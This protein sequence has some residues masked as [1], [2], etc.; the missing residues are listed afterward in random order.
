M[1]RLCVLALLA[2]AV[3]AAAG[4]SP[5]VETAATECV[6]KYGPMGCRSAPGCDAVGVPNCIQCQRPPGEIWTCN[7]CQT[8]FYLAND[9]QCSPCPL[10][11]YCAGIDLVW[12]DSTAISEGLTTAAPGQWAPGQC[13]G[14]SRPLCSARGA[15]GR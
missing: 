15:C 10:G 14:E 1:A 11:A 6:Y 12:C 2:L 13:N 8:G 4:D 5:S 3:V 9:G 7:I